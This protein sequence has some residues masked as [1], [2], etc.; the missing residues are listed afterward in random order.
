MA[1]DAGPDVIIS[2]A[3][4]YGIPGETGV[5]FADQYSP[6]VMHAP[7]VMHSPDVISAADA[8]GAI[9]FDQHS[10][11]VISAVDAY[12]ISPEDVHAPDVISAADAYGI[13]LDTGTRDA[14]EEG[15]AADATTGEEADGGLDE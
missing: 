11:D 13:A 14:L 8:Y 6:D 7:D 10:P 3:D 9:Y 2:V 15:D 5:F 1:A 12:G 4:A